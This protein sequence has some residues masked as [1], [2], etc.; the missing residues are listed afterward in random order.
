MAKKMGLGRGLDALLPEADDQENLVREIPVSEIDRNPSQPRRKFDE[1]ALQSLSDSIRQSG[2]LSPLLVVQADG[3]YRLVAGERRLR[4]SLMAGL[5][6]VPCVV[7]DFTRQQEM[8]AAL[9]ENLQRED[10]DPMEEAEGIRALMEQCGYTQEKAAERLGKSRPAVANSLRLL[11]LE[12]EITA[13]VRSGRL[14]A[15]HARVLC[16]IHDKD[17]RL[18]LFHR[19]M[20]ERLNVRQLELLAADLAAGVKPKPGKKPPRPLSVELKDMQDRLRN[21]VG[22]QRVSIQ[23]G[24]KRG[25][26]IL[27]YAS[28]EELELIYAAL[29]TLEGK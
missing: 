29:E 22:V 14:S 25:R 11:T 2:V 21:A 7:R 12:D 28:A 23:G 4:A 20:N 1:E 13:E 18:R 3:R 15:G 9:V 5:R 17:A 27:S 19:V 8:E 26:V 10:L 6:T 16:G 24:E